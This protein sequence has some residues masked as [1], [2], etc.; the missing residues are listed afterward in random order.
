MDAMQQIQVMPV[1]R[2]WYTNPVTWILAGVLAIAAGVGSWWYFDVHAKQVLNEEWNSLAVATLDDAQTLLDTSQTLAALQADLAAK[3]PLPDGGVRVNDTV[4]EARALIDGLVSEVPG[5][6][7]AL[8]GS[9][10]DVS[11]AGYLTDLDNTYAID[12]GTFGSGAEFL[13]VVQEL[14]YVDAAGQQ[15]I[16][17]TTVKGV[18]ISLKED[19]VQ[20]TQ[21]DIDALQQWSDQIAAYNETIAEEAVT[22]AYSAHGVLLTR[23][24]DA[25]TGAFNALAAEMSAATT[26]LTDSADKVADNATREALQ[27]AINNAAAIA[28]QAG[29]LTIA[30]LTQS[31]NDLAAVTAALSQ[32][33]QAVRDSMTAKA[34]A[35]RAAAAQQGSSGYTYYDPWSDPG[36]TWYDDEYETYDPW[37]DP[38]DSYDPWSDPGDDG[39]YY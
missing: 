20:K 29:G 39:Y 11:L 22:V 16:G 5:F 1:K 17:A 26:L 31:T 10:L 37:S 3:A 7:L 36:D 30:S 34:E 32:A 19:G 25:N 33:E 21:E 14:G 35:D 6:T 15:L 2:R 18:V 27:S 8:E 13:T 38:G 12:P 23:A 9:D 24:T 28:D 4:S